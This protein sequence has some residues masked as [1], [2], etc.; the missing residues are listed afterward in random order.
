MLSYR[1]H[2]FEVKP[3]MGGFVQRAVDVNTCAVYNSKE[4]NKLPKEIM[5]QLYSPPKVEDYLPDSRLMIQENRYIY[6]QEQ[7]EAMSPGIMTA[8]ACRMVHRSQ[9]E[10]AVIEAGGAANYASYGD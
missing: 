5:H 1:R 7:L 6:S 4:L 9:L 3:S 8:S 10:R 2:D